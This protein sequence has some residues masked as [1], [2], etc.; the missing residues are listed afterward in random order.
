MQGHGEINIANGKGAKM[1]DK[2]LDDIEIIAL[3]LGSLKALIGLSRIEDNDWE[4]IADVLNDYSFRLRLAVDELR[5]NMW[6]GE[7]CRNSS[8]ERDVLQVRA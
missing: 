4:R 3:S 5:L 7:T 8:D 6:D 1:I 2:H